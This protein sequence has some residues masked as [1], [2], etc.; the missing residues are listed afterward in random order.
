MLDVF[1]NLS[2]KV[3]VTC[4]TLGLFLLAISIV[5]Y[6]FSTHVRDEL[7]ITLSKNQFSEVASVAERIDNAII[8]RINSI[9]LLAASITPQLMSHGNQLS[10]FLSVQNL[11]NKQFSLGSIIISKEGKGVADFPKIEGRANADF[12][13]FDYFHQ[14]ML[15]GKPYISRP[16]KGQFVKEPRLVI[17][18]PIFDKGRHVVGIFAGVM[19]LKD[20]SF[21]SDFDK[22][23]HLNSSSYQIVAP[24]DNLIVTSTDNGQIM[25]PLPVV[26]IDSMFDQYRNGYEGSGISV[27]SSGIEA[28]S[29]AKRISSVG[30]FVVG[31]MPTDQ[32]FERIKHI[33][34]EAILVSSIVSVFFILLFWLFLRHELLPLERSV[35]RIQTQADKNDRETIPLEGSPEIQ[36]LQTSFNQLQTR[37]ARDEGL[38]R[39]NEALY[40]AMFENHTAVKWLVDYKSGAIVDANAAAARFYGWTIEQLR[41]MNI[42]QINTLP[43]EMIRKEMALAVNQQ[44]LFFRFKHRLASGEI[45][46]VE[47]NSS[48]INLDGRTFPS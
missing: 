15:T 14:V 42:S 28:L 6:Q 16:A 31:S 11:I 17:A 41:Q 39:A 13:Q 19:G 35:K 24:E 43:A 10:E 47:V 33:R 27:N 12:A 26:G 2:L 7:E 32:A 21:I 34:N 40:R 45:R 9:S 1:H 30:W 48:E 46:D 20:N 8:F 23:T 4:F 36:R 37:I 3:K 29:S 18:V 38:L 25:K 5:T 44:R 22:R